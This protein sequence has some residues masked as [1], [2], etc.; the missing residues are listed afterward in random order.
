LSLSFVSKN[1]ENCNFISASSHF[2]TLNFASDKNNCNLFVVY[3]TYKKLK[4]M[5]SLMYKLWKLVDFNYQSAANIRVRLLNWGSDFC[6]SRP[7]IDLTSAVRIYFRSRIPRRLSDRQ[8]YSTRRMSA[9]MRPCH[10]HLQTHT[11]NACVFVRGSLKTRFIWPN[12][13]AATS[14]DERGR[15]YLWKRNEQARDAC[16]NAASTPT[17]N[18]TLSIS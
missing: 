14:T 15:R 16:Y 1:E 2:N 8:S 11:R 10:C 5:E 9:R 7:H 12:Y 18:R 6:T 17:V 13:C 4:F 3:V